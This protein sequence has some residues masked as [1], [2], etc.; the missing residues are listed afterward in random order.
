[1]SFCVS[2]S[3]WSFSSTII[4][5][6]RLRSLADARL[7]FPTLRSLLYLFLFAIAYHI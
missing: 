7:K 2:A 1:M 5:W 3:A 6:T 4:D